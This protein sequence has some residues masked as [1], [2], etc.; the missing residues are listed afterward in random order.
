VQLINN[1][2]LN[3]TNQHWLLTVKNRL[4]P[5][6]QPH[7]SSWSNSPVVSKPSFTQNL[8]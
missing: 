3:T 7:L 2:Q 1:Q 6:S 8:L 4:S 5:T